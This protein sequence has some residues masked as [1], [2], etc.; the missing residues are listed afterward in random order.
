MNLLTPNYSLWKENMFQYTLKWISFHEFW[1]IR[2]EVQHFCLSSW[3]L[4]LTYI[5]TVYAFS[6]KK[7]KKKKNISE[8]D[9]IG[10][11]WIICL[12]F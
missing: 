1:K 11:I 5:F 4:N 7:K 12:D 9:I 8:I 6:K 3:T 2:S 10:L